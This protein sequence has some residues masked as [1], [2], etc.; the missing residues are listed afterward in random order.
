MENA[1]RIL[2]GEAREGDEY[3]LRRKNGSEFPVFIRASRTVQD[4]RVI[5]L[6]GIVVDLTQSKRAEEEKIRLEEQVRQAQK[7]EAIGTLAGGIAHD[8]N[9]ILAA[10]IGFTEMA[11]D[12]APEGSPLRPK[13]DRA[14]KASLRGRDLVKQI[15]TFSRKAEQE[16]RYVALTPLVKETLRF[17]RASLPATIEI[18]LDSSSETDLVLADPT[19]IEQV[20][21]NLATNAAYAMGNKG[22]LLELRM[23]DTLIPS[24]EVSDPD[25]QPGT[26]LRVSVH[27]TGCGMDK[28]TLARIFDP[29]FTTKGPGEGTG[30]GLSVVHG[31][32]KAHRGAITVSSQPGKGSTFTVYLPKAAPPVVQENDDISSI[33]TGSERILLVDDE[34][35]I[36][37]VAQATLQGL[38]Y[39]VTVMRDGV[40]AIRVFSETPDLFDL[41][42]TDQNMPNITGMEL[43]REVLAIRPNIPVV[44]CTGYSEIV[45]PDPEQAG[46]RGYI[47]K[48]VTRRE[49]AAGIRHALH[50]HGRDSEEKEVGV[51]RSNLRS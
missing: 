3:V 1:E 42:V 4:G 30:L 50:R 33:E 2:A 14:H 47:R 22:G 29:F 49:L 17:L 24:S 19:Q 31:I 28:P 20:I 12:D 18:Q 8:F 5:G 10:V 39:H 51:P 44:L 16:R 38:G 23:S 32:V 35:D 9:N 26:Y 27:D 13:L 15:L 37:D 45:P 48:P 40:E 21:V 36:I 41:V 6:R 11:I 34:K 25:L 7:M 46:L 43:A